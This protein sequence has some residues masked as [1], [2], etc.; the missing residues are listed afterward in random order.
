VVWLTAGL[1]GWLV[2]RAL[3]RQPW[4]RGRGRLATAAGLIFAGAAMGAI[5]VTWA[6][7]QVPGRVTTGSQLDAL[8]RLSS[9]RRL[10]A[11]SLSPLQRLDRADLAAR[12]TLAPE[13]STLPGGAGRNDRPLFSIAAV[14]AGE[15]RLRSRVSAA[16]GWLM[17]GIGRDQFAIR[18]VP[19]EEAA[20]TIVV[21]LPVDV[22]AL[23][24]RG[25]EDARRNLTG[26][27]IDPVR[28]VMPEDRLAPG[29]ARQAVRYDAATVWFLDD[30]SFPEPE[31]FWIRGERASEIVIQPDQPH[32]ADGLFL[33][34]GAEANTVLIE[35]KGWRE[36]LRLGAGEERT[37]Q[38]PSDQ[39]R[40]ATWLRITTSAG[41]T[42]S[43][44]E[45]NS[46]D[47]RFLG[48]WVKVG[49]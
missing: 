13:F 28:L 33:R 24:V 29:Y 2:L 34:N 19:L 14:P 38:V 46:Q 22:R 30:R 1:G 32:P 42:P 11:L 43:A 15:Y 49:G 35:G 21:H 44:V 31:G 39:A 26:L 47:Q 23:I 40:N 7:E 25:D 6:A 37:V 41:F 17:I 27:E 9:E 4:L 3:E 36:E 48:V 8:R 10:V 18:T 16:S 12:L 45:P 5:A 20:K